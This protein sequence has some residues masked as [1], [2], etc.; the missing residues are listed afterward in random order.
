[1]SRTEIDGVEIDWKRV[2]RAAEAVSAILKEGSLVGEAK[3]QKA[4]AERRQKWGSRVYWLVYKL[5][6]MNKRM[7]IYRKLTGTVGG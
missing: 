4:R 3:R 1:M 2:E 7:P 6:P 5:I